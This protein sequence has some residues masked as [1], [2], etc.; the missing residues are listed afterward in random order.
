MSVRLVSFYSILVLNFHVF[1]APNLQKT[2]QHSM[3]QYSNTQDITFPMISDDIIAG[4][5]SEIPS[6]T[7]K[8]AFDKLSY[9]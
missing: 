1:H 3:D 6:S 7:T 5:F 9:S 2:V 8:A 4:I